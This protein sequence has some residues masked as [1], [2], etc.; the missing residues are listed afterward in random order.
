MKC[1]L[2]PGDDNLTI[3]SGICAPEMIAA[4]FERHSILYGPSQ[5]QEFIRTME[6]RSKAGI[7]IPVC[8]E[9]NGKQVC[10]VVHDLFLDEA[11]R[12]LRVSGFVDSST[13]E[14]KVIRQ[15]MLSGELGELSLGVSHFIAMEKDTRTGLDDYYRA[16]STL[17]EISLVER[18]NASVET[19]F[20][21]QRCVI[22]TVASDKPAIEFDRTFGKQ[23]FPD[24]S[25]V[26]HERMSASSDSQAHPSGGTPP[27]ANSAPAAAEQTNEMMTQ[28][29]AM[30]AKMEEMEKMLGAERLRAKEAGEKLQAAEIEKQLNA[31]KAKHGPGIKEAKEILQLFLSRNPNDKQKE[32]FQSAYS[33][34]ERFEKEPMLLLDEDSVIGLNN[35]LNFTTSTYEMIGGKAG[36][37]A[38]MAA[39]AAQQQAQQPQEIP[40]TAGQKS[41]HRLTSQEADFQRSRQELLRAQQ[42]LA[43]A[44]EMN[45]RLTQ[46]NSAAPVR[47]SSPFAF[48]NTPPQP[49]APQQKP[50]AQA[51]PP[52][53]VEMADKNKP[54]LLMKNPLAYGFVMQMADKHRGDNAKLTQELQR[55]GFVEFKTVASD[56]NPVDEEK[57]EQLKMYKQ[58]WKM[59]PRTGAPQDLY[60]TAG[61]CDEIRRWTEKRVHVPLASFKP[62]SRYFNGPA[63]DGFKLVTAPKKDIAKN[64][65]HK[66]Q[67]LALPHM[68]LQRV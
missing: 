26:D 65:T 25:K 4:E 55:S 7:R 30:K 64:K 50:A 38:S 49:A 59:H 31:A 58:F 35:V 10:G 33:Q 12:G 44:K 18:G 46:M 32:A 34:V 61:E 22:D 42:Q 16:E 56:K 45:R 27:P 3:F 6:E 52:A 51:V 53:D 17:H 1:R 5:I 14:G 54:V 48:W 13:P 19:P 21:E 39:F 11:S 9:H 28:F 23:L 15:K 68:S 63:R 29:E 66:P 20:G 43:E 36:L 2:Q 47:P 67:H 62:T 57:E 60:L 24:V 37:D 40:T 8:L 41:D